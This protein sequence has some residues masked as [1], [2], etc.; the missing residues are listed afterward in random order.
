MARLS[1]DSSL[2]ALAAATSTQGPRLVVIGQGSFS[3]RVS[4][5][6]KIRPTLWSR[7]EKLAAGQQYLLVD[8]ALQMLIDQLEKRNPADVLVV[9][10]ASL[11]AT[12]EDQFIANEAKSRKRRLNLGPVVP[13]D[14]D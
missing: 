13:N 7:L 5:L 9:R 1:T 4:S 12:A 2:A 8:L 11:A 10:A 3:G 6:I 14:K